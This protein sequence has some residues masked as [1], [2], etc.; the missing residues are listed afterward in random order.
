M[1]DYIEMTDSELINHVLH[2]SPEVDLDTTAITERLM[3]RSQQLNTFTF[4][5]LEILDYKKDDDGNFTDVPD[6]SI[7][8]LFGALENRIANLE[9]YEANY[10]GDKV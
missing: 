2:N 1:T 5:L 3:I 4:K 7:E 10:E 8:D 6:L 9:S